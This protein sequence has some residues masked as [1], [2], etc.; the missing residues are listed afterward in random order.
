MVVA[1]KNTCQI[2]NPLLKSRLSQDSL[3]CSERN[4]VLNADEI[5]GGVLVDRATVV[6]LVER[7][8]TKASYKSTWSLDHILITGDSVPWLVLVPS[9][10]TLLGLY[11]L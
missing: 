9:K 8:A 4:L 7:F 11:R 1:S 3:A 10:N 2:S 6:A 5:R